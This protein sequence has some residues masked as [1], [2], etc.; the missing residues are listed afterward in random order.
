[1]T[2]P[3]CLV[4]G[5]SGGIGR[6]TISALKRD[7]WRILATSLGGPGMLSPI[8]DDD[9]TYLDQDL[10]AKTAADDIVR[11]AVGKYGCLNGLVHCAGTSHVAAFPDQQDEDWERV[12]D[13]NL[14]S[15][16]RIARAAGRAMVEKGGGAMVFISSIAW[17]SGGANPAY[18][19]AKGGINSLTFNIA[20]ALG[21]RGV[22]AN[23]IAPGIIATDMVRGAFPGASFDRLALAASART[24][25]RRLG[26]AVDVA[27]V[28]AF[29]LS[30]RAGFLTGAVIP[31][32]GGIE[33]IPPIGNLAG[34]ES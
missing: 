9:D 2:L 33:L 25:L 21:P 14:S 23:A 27:E 11:Q 29:L 19:A 3:V 8:L 4:T 6:A 1:M 22:R 20:Q 34:S 30:P 13:I 5:A 28:A 18:G 31:V 32:T 15:A 10:T 26:E 7:G 12:L 16:H 17:L 24:P